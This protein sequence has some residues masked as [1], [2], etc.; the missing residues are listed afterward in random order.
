MA[1]AHSRSTFTG[2][3][4]SQRQISDGHAIIQKLNLPNI[5]LHPTNPSSTLAPDFGQFELHPR[6]RR[7]LLGPPKRPNQKSST[8]A[9]KI[10][11]PTASPTISYNTYPGWHARRRHPAKC[12]GTTP[13]TL[14]IPTTASSP[15]ASSSP[16]SPNP[17]SRHR[18]RLHHPPPPGTR[19]PPAHPR[20]LPPP[21]TSRTSSTNPS[22]FHQVH[23]PRR[24]KKK[25]PIPRRSPTLRHDPLPLRHRRRKSHPRLSPD[26]LHMEQY[27][28]FLRNRM[29]RQTLSSVTTTFPSTTPSAP[30]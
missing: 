2:I 10:S 4:L 29:F 20:H 11:P 15:H 14:K 19:P 26:L 22:H 7:L 21:R 6:P 16:S 27:M 28:D 18:S 24:R 12:S 13:S 25:P 3:D 8:S 1:L 9:K 23:R 30:K 17:F 5:H